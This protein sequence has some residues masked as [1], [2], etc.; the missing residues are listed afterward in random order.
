MPFIFDYTANGAKK[1]GESF[2]AWLGARKV[3]GKGEIGLF[4]AKGPLFW[5]KSPAFLY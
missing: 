1:K 2:R 3:T 4:S 5:Q